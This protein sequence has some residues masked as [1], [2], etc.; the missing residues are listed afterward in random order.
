MGEILLVDGVGRPKIIHA[1]SDD[2]PQIMGHARQHVAS[3]PDRIAAFVC[4]GEVDADG[5][6]IYRQ[7][8]THAQIRT[9]YLRVSPISAFNP[10]KVKP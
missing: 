1:E 6:I 3:G 8:G 9:E 4:T 2:Y 7:E 10:P 5:R